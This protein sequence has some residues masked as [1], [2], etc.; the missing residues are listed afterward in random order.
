MQDQI[1]EG[2]TIDEG[3]E[4]RTGRTGAARKIHLPGAAPV[5]GAADIGQ[6]IARPVLHHHNGNVGAIVE[7]GPLLFRQP[8][9]GGLKGGI[10]SCLNLKNPLR[11]QLTL[12]AFHAFAH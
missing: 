7:I 11:F 6:H 2:P 9:G 12:G 3:L 1:V 8:F 4:R 10:E 5:I